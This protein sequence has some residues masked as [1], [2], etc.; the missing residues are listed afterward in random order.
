MNHLHIS[1]LLDPGMMLHHKIML[2]LMVVTMGGFLHLQMLFPMPLLVSFFYLIDLKLQFIV[3]L[4]FF[5]ANSV[6][7][8]DMP[9]PYPGL[10]PG[11]A[12]NGYTPSS[13]GNYQIFFFV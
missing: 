3:K 10:Y 4:I 12:G 2:L 7:M 6:Y 5:L 9:P 13:N 8:T 1:H 11:N